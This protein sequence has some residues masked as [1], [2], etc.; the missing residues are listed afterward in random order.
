M[1]TLQRKSLL[2]YLIGGLL[3]KLGS[4]IDKITGRNWKPSSSLATSELIDRIKKML[5]FEVRKNGTVKFVPHEIKIRIQWDKFS[6]A[7]SLDKLRSEILVAII[8]HINDNLYHT[9]APLNLEIK[10]DYFVDGLVLR[11]SFGEFASGG[12]ELVINLDKNE[13]SAVSTKEQELEKSSYSLLIKYL[14]DPEGRFIEIPVE[15][16]SVI[17]IGRAKENH[18]VLENPSVSKVHASLKITA[19]GEILISDLGSTNGTFIN[20]ERLDIGK[21]YQLDRDSKLRIGTVELS[22]TLRDRDRET[23]HDISSVSSGS[24]FTTLTADQFDIKRGE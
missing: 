19:N 7:G 20:G 9:Y 23:Q 21:A 11:A 22:I 16:G 18:A 5:D 8:D 12:A 3:V 4:F 1:S 14:N 10:P 17:S 13:A 24:S 6:N 15:T 2:D